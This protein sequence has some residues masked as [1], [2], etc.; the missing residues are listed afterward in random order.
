M[1]PGDASVV[2]ARQVHLAYRTRQFLTQTTQSRH[3]QFCLLSDQCR[4]ALFQRLELLLIR[5]ESHRALRRQLLSPSGIILQEV[6]RLREAKESLNDR[7]IIRHQGL[8]PLSK[9]IDLEVS[10]VG[11]RVEQWRRSIVSWVV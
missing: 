6:M 7:T 4:V 10:R 11:R 9:G 3:S 5:L 8:Y 1:L 2:E